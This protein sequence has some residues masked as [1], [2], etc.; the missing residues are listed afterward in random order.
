MWDSTTLTVAGRPARVRIGGDGAPLVLLHGGW[1]GA[2]AHWGPVFDRFATRHRVV[3]PELPGLGGGEA[4]PTYEQYAR[5]VLALLDALG[6]HERVACVGNSLGAAIATSLAAIAPG[7]LSAIVL[8]NGGTRADRIPAV[9]I[10]RR[11]P[12]GLRV[13]RWMVR[14]NTYSPA[15]IARAFSDPRRAPPAVVAT[16]SQPR[17]PQLDVVLP[18]FLAGEPDGTVRVPTF[19]VWGRQDRLIGVSLALARRV[20]R[21][22]HAERLV[23]ID[24]AGHLPQVEQPDAFV[25]AVEGCLAGQR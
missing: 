22:L 21:D 19:V 14:S 2:E 24:D 13:L 16:V 5:W 23:V 6:I 4:L 9:R 25:A 18:L 8:V 7:R 12:G 1:A 15:T 17:P 20:A 10:L 3:A 11:L